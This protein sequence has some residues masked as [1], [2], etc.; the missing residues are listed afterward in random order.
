MKKKANVILVDIDRRYIQLCSGSDNFNS[1]P[2]LLTE[3]QLCLSLQV[4]T[5]STWAAASSSGLVMTPILVP[6]VMAYHLWVAARVRPGTPTA[7]SEAESTAP[8]DGG[9]WEREGGGPLGL[10]STYSTD[11]ESVLQV[12]WRVYGGK[13]AGCSSVKV[14]EMVVV[15]VETHGKQPL[16]PLLSDQVTT[17]G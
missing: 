16:M 11:S 5:V 17:E 1:L 2:L 7:V 4:Y 8:P 10:M 13:A 3:L 15:V 9:N 6:T 14:K 12:P